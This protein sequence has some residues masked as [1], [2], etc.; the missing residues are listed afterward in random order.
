MQNGSG[1]L[2][3]ILNILHNIKNRGGTVSICH[4]DHEGPLCDVCLLNSEKK[5]YKLANTCLGCPSIL[6]SIL[7]NLGYVLIS[8][9]FTLFTIR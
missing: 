5:F 6:Q 1:L 8:L 4:P 3:L 9:A 2:V 7:Y